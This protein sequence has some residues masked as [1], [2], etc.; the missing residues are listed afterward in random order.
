M[1][2]D[3]ILVGVESLPSAVV[4]FDGECHLCDGFVRFILDRDWEARFRFAPLQSAYARECFAGAGWDPAGLDSVVVL[5]DDHFY[6]LSDAVLEILAELP[7]IWSLGRHFRVIPRA[8]RNA[9]YRW[10]AANRYRFFGRRKTCRMPREG[11]A[12]RFLS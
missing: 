9:V 1:I 11:E 3:P 6:V 10:V 7:G 12:E 4:F 2:A 5:K 8:W